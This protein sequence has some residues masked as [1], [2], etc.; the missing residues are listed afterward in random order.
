MAHTFVTNSRVK[1]KRVQ[2]PNRKICLP[3][4][5]DLI[6]LANDASVLLVASHGGC[7]PKHNKYNGYRAQLYGQ[8]TSNKTWKILN[9]TA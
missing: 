4:K 1:W 3:N 5:K 9:F 7:P 8:S 6:R 2:R